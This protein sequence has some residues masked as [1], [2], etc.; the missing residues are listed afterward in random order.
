MNFIKY[1]LKTL[2][3][4]Y[5]IGAILFTLVGV[6]IHGIVSFPF[7]SIPSIFLIA[8]IIC[9]LTFNYFIK[10]KWFSRLGYIV[11]CIGFEVLLVCY[12]FVSHFED[13]E[14]VIEIYRVLILCSVVGG[15][16]SFICL[17]RITKS[18]RWAASLPT[19]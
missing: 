13:V 3:V 18:R 11:V 8:P 4:S 17:E 16:A 2:F 7:Y 19:G 9:Y 1:I 15:I 12:A 5:F 6:L 14:G 10:N